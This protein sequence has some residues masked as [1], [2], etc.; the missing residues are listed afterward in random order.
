MPSISARGTLSRDDLLSVATYTVWHRSWSVRILLILGSF[1][2]L[3]AV[4]DL[5]GG[6]KGNA[7]VPLLLGLFWISY[8]FASPRLAIR[9]QLKA[10]GHLSEEATYEFDATQFSIRRPSLQV[11][12]LWKTVHSAVELKQAF[13]IFTSRTCFFCI[14]KRFFQANEI[15]AFRDVLEVALRQHGK[16]LITRSPSTEAV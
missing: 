1:L 4:C 10:S 8:A 11:S 2:L 14:P 7:I 3:L 5:L 6:M 12:L 13:A 15:H 16:K 9:K